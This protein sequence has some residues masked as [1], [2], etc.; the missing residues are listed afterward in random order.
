MLHPRHAAGLQVKASQD[1][2]QPSPQQQQEQQEQ[3]AQPAQP[4]QPTQR[5]VDPRELLL[6]RKDIELLDM[7]LNDLRQDTSRLKQDLW[8]QTG[9]L[10]QQ[11]L[12][13]RQ[14]TSG[15]KHMSHQTYEGKQDT[16]LVAAQWFLNVMLLILYVSL[17]RDMV[18]LLN[19]A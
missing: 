9:D 17:A 19:G 3:P 15:L 8:Q 18:S 2:S 14:Q 16:V 7:K 1:E 12:D 11:I 4:P 5:V 10:W 13:I 6:L